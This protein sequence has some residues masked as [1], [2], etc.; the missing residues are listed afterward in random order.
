MF[1]GTY[2][3]TLPLLA[4]TCI[5]ALSTRARC[6]LLCR[7]HLTG[8]A[9]EGRIRAGRCHWPAPPKTKTPPFVA[10]TRTPWW[11]LI[12]PALWPWKQRIQQVYLLKWWVCLN[13]TH[14][15]WKTIIVLLLLCNKMTAVADIIFEGKLLVVALNKPEMWALPWLLV[16]YWH[17]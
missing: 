15:M 8:E 16:P 9:N 4:Y 11:K 3:V 12:A 2:I 5:A 6:P 17:R 7:M 10:T 14:P 13:R 1:T